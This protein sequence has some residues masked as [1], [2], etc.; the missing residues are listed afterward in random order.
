MTC[1]YANTLVKSPSIAAAELGSQQMAQGSM[2]VGRLSYPINHITAAN[3]DGPIF[4][5]VRQLSI[6]L[7][8]RNRVD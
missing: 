5:R 4:I 6:L 7:I 2:P 1:Q 8:S 3:Q